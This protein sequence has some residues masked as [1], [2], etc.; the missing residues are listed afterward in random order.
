MSDVIREALLSKDF[1]KSWN[2]DS[3]TASRQLAAHDELD[4]LV[5][6]NEALRLR[7][8]VLEHAID[9]VLDDAGGRGHRI[10]RVGIAS[11]DAL[12]AAREA[13]LQPPRA[14]ER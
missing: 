2:E 9:R 3:E 11:L 7:A 6:D 10:Y 5:A 1:L 8:A 14:H 13:R 4:K 12:R